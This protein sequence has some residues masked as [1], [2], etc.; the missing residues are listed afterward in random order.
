VDFSTILIL[1]FSAIVAFAT[2]VGAAIAKRSMPRL[3]WPC[4]FSTLAAALVFL[5]LPEP[6]A[7][8][9]WVFTLFGL[10]VSAAIGTVIGGV[11]AR[12][13]ITAICSQR[14]G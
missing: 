13:L 3:I 4:A 14:R 7:L 1:P 12:V 9:L 5:R 11:T 2:L 8:G 6:S 10:A